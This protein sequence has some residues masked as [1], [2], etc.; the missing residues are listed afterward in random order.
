MGGHKQEIGDFKSNS[1]GGRRPGT[2]QGYGKS[3]VAP[4]AAQRAQ[5]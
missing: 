5:R 3:Q 4:G 2:R 1:G